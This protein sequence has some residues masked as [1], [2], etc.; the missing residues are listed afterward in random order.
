MQYVGIDVSKDSLQVAVLGNLE[1]TLANSKAGRLKL[2]RMLERLSDEVRVVLEPTASYHFELAKQLVALERVEVM[3][4]NP[5]T[6]A[7]FAKVLDQRG[8]CDRKD[9]EMLARFAS[10]MEF[11]AWT[12]PTASCQTLRAYVRRRHQLVQQRTREKVRLKEA[13]ETGADAFL[14]EDLRGSIDELEC[15]IHRWEQ[16]ALTVVKEDGEL[17]H[18]HDQ[19]KTI[20]GVGDVTAS[21]VLA[22]LSHLDST[23]DVR[24]LTAYA[25]LD[26]TPWQSGK[27]DARR[28]I[29]KRGNKRLRTA[30]YL[31]A[32]NAARFAPQV[33]AWKES[34]E[35]RGKAPNVAY[36]AVARRLLHA[37]WGMRRTNTDWSGDRFYSGA[38]V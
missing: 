34:L 18:W 26:P 15:R 19:L 21:V 30:M 28:H 9:A 7:A 20:P 6:T 22:E 5:R 38:S 10:A 2:A 31:A 23:M 24:Q 8:K 27:M 14:I 17:R 1:A 32:W 36:I 12:P 3:V 35:Q 16:R 29:S 25:G 33:R 11:R 4:A 37:I 13:L